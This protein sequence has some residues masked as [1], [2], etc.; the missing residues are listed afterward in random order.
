VTVRQWPNP[1]GGDDLARIPFGENVVDDL[2]VMPEGYGQKLANME[3][4]RGTLARRRPF[5]AYSTETWPD[6]ITNGTEYIDTSDTAR[7]LLGSEDGYIYEYTAAG[8]HANRVTGLTVDKRSSF[9]QMIGAVL[10]QNATDSPRRGDD[11]TWRV[12]GA[13]I[14]ATALTLGANAAGAKTGTFIWMVTAC[15]RDGAGNVI[16]ESDHSNYATAT[17]AAQNQAL[18]WTASTDARVDRYRVYV[19]KTGQGSPFYLLT[20]QAGVTYTDNT[21]DASLSAQIA[22]PLARNGVMPISA[23]ITQAGGRAVCAKLTDATDPNA[24]KAVHVSIIATNRYEMEYYPNDGLHKFYLPGP[25]PCTAAIG[26]SSKDEDQAAKDLFLSQPTSCYIL[27]G[28]DPVNGVLEPISFEVGVVSDRAI[29][30][31]GRFIFFVSRRGLEFLGS[32]GEPKLISPHVRSYFFGGGSLGLSAND[33]DQY[34]TLAIHENR[35]L[36]T[37]RDSSSH[38]WGNKALVM[39]LDRFNPYEAKPENTAIFTHW[40]GTGLG[41]SFFIPTR[42]GGLLLVDN[43]NKR[44]LQRASSGYQD[45][46][47]AVATNIPARIWTGGMMSRG[48]TYLKVIRHANILQLSDVDCTMDL[49]ADYGAFDQTMITIPRYAQ[50]VTWDKVWDKSWGATSVFLSTVY[51]KRDVRGRLFQAKIKIENATP[52]YIYIGMSLFYTATRARRLTKR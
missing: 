14:A 17:L 26:Y 31:W 34:I 52:E 44:V 3:Y 35:L 51:I 42:A 19:T 48:M 11:T 7:I 37:L 5:T 24:S 45:T 22:D 46:V 41:L 33:G 30:Q 29:T 16:L 28:A 13:P 20:T 25:G 1:D 2:A 27:R 15:I 36:I 21:A 49:E 40:N 8:T 50:S 32:E 4:R 6:I 47:N 9:A 38:T 10:H 23:F 18:S 12:A 39:D 43:K